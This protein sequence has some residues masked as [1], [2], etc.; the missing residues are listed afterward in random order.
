MDPCF[1]GMTPKLTI[2]HT[3]H[4]LKL[5]DLAK[6]FG[7]ANL[8]LVTVAV[9]HGLGSHTHLLEPE[10]ASKALEITWPA[11]WMAMLS[12]ALGKVMACSFLLELDGPMAQRRRWLLYFIAVSNVSRL[13][14][15]WMLPDQRQDGNI[16]KYQTLI[17]ST[18]GN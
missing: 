9:G 16:S 5:A 2:S 14:F 3:V 10:Q 7:V 12:L 1:V 11:Q 17:A 13:H 4:F 8:V 6:I 18:D 15:P